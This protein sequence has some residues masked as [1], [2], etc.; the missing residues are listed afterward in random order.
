MKLQ[1]NT[2]LNKPEI[3][4]LDIDGT[5]YDAKTNSIP[6]HT[7]TALH[8]LRK[9][10]IKLILCTARSAQEADNLPQELSDAVDGWILL[11]GSILNLCGKVTIK[12]IASDSL[13]KLLAY[14]DER[15]LKFRFVDEKQHDYLI[16]DD[17][18]IKKGF[19]KN[20]NWIPDIKAYEQETLI[21]LLVF[22]DDPCQGYEMMQLAP[23]L[24]YVP[25]PR[26]CEITPS[27]C[28]KGKAL[29][30]AC[31]NLDIDPAHA[32]AI[33]DGKSD[34]PM[35]ETVYGIAMGNSKDEV[36]EKAAIV[37]D[38]LMNDGF[39]KVVKELNWI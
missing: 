32:A 39:Y 21:Q 24:S 33:G 12:T 10:G 29:L 28:D 23:E 9:N 7:M 30:E 34:I 17:E 35:F 25:L 15:K 26:V 2:V 4:F 1:K 20:Y 36:K 31:R 11:S 37:A 16:C 8:E 19:I 13:N 3:L 6:K 18:T 38:T 27:D 5:L 14:L 22:L